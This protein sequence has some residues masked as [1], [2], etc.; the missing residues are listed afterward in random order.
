MLS[1]GNLQQYSKSPLE[2]DL[3]KVLS[4]KTKSTIRVFIAIT[5]KT[6]LSYNDTYAVRIRP[7][8]RG[9]K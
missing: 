4:K 2:T 3:I 1:L 5:V 8:G 9:A 6:N 7:R